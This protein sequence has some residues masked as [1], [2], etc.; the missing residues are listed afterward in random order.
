MEIHQLEYFLAVADAG[1]FSRAA[2]RIGIAQPSLSQQIKKLEHELGQPL[3]DRL[4]RGVSL[5]AAG[6]SFCTDAR[7]ILADLRD[8]AQRVAENKGEVAGT[9]RLGAIP[10]VAPFLLPDLCSRF[11]SMHSDVHLEIVED[12]SD[13][14]ALAIAEGRIDLALMSTPPD[15]PNL[16]AE[17]L[18]DDPLGLLLPAAHVLANEAN[19]LSID[20]VADEPVLVLHELH[21]L[22]GQASD[23]CAR[24][25]RTT[26]VIFQGEQLT[27][28]IGMVAANLGV[29]VV[30]KMAAALAQQSGCVWRSID[31][32]SAQ[33][34]I[35]AVTNIARYRGAPLRAMLELL[36]A[37][38]RG[39]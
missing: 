1:G 4:P 22:A 10:T 26:P 20:A 27:T 3:F 18:F 19:V 33:R 14:L 12:V 8:A 35:F 39:D 23:L 21:C 2:G 6:E 28:V 30:P 11:L 34:T 7:Q 9:L 24:H 5:T 29:S 38:D 15:A 31:D 25:R 17:R 36:R 37:G 13:R 16:N 32:A